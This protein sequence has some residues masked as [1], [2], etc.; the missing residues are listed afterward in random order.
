ME[1]TADRGIPPPAPGF[2]RRAREWLRPLQ[3][4][5]R[6][7]RDTLSAWLTAQLEIETRARSG[8][9]LIPIAL[10]GG[11]VLVHGLGWRPP[12]VPTFCAGALLLLVAWLA[13]ARPHWQSALLVAGMGMAGAGL[14]TAEISRTPTTVFSGESTVRIVGTVVARERDDR[15]RYRYMIDVAATD[16]P[17]LSRPPERV[18]I[19]AASRHRP[20]AP[21]EVYSGLVRL[22]PPSGPAYPGS[23]DFAYQPFFDGVGAFG[24]DLGAPDEKPDVTGLDHAPGIVGRVR[25]ELALVRL[26]VTERIQDT[27]GGPA[28][29]I[30][31]ALITGERAAIP[32]D[33]VEW[34]RSTGLAHVLSISGL[35]MAIVAGFALLLVRSLLALVAP[36]ALRLPT[37]KIA[38]VAALAVATF[39]LGISGANV[40]TQRAYVMLAVMLV[41]I[42]FDRP[43]LTLR[44]LS[45]AAIVVVVLRPHAVMTASFQ[46]SFAATAAL[47]GGYATWNAW[48]RGRG[49]AAK[50]RKGGVARPVL[51]ALAAIFAT[52]LFAGTATAPYSAYHF[53]RVALL[54]FV[55]NLLTMPIFSFWIMP[56]ALIGGLLMPLGLDGWIFHLMGAGISLVL[57]IARMVHER[58]PDRGVGLMT[59]EGL[60]LLT[61]AILAGSFFTSG[62]KW[63]AVPLA[64]L[65]LALAPDRAP[66]PELLVFEDGKEVATLSAEGELA[67]LRK[68]PNDFVAQ[69]WERAF[70]PGISP[71]SSERVYLPADCV[72][73]FC[74]F[75]TRSGVRVTWTDDY[76]KT[77]QACDQGDVAIVAR[78]IRLTACR[79]GAALMTLRTLRR[80]GSVA[81][82]ADPAGGR[83]LVVTAIEEPLAEWNRHRAAPWPEFW[84][85]PAEDDAPTAADLPQVPA[86]AAS[87]GSA[88]D[89]TAGLAQPPDAARPETA[90]E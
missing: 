7:P 30:A 22:R 70:M 20:I 45:I 90:Q 53:H 10:I 1:A 51:F 74:R 16:R 54:G 68:R 83:P 72:D 25:T 79:S 64:G 24:F 41:A 73:G 52:S 3:R 21:G 46:M 2:L 85:K 50:P 14:G 44:N 19:L 63:L 43:A 71:G 26:A 84:R 81:I 39:Y 17:V 29:A 13:A 37:K 56:L 87:A 40:A 57:E 60:L 33:A 9:H 88:S 28:G 69:Q 55:A 58:L 61:A 11:V 77:G 6:A 42:L 65:G 8:F 89:A 18:R 78:A 23:Y 12:P 36:I 34:L 32:D 48:R 31:A 82:A 38:A 76:E 35:H 62:F 86:Q 5:R 27:I 47:I 15:G 75:T 59:G 66:L 80:S 4:F 67:F 49:A